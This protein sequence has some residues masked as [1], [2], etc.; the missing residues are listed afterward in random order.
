VSAAR[1]SPALSSRTAT[2]RS[3]CS[4]GARG[5]RPTASGVSLARVG[6]SRASSHGSAPPSGV[7]VTA[8]RVAGSSPS[9]R[10]ARAS[11]KPSWSGSARSLAPN[12]IQYGRSGVSRAPFAPRMTNR[13][14]DGGGAGSGGGTTQPAESARATTNAARFCSMGRL[15]TGPG[16]ARGGRGTCA[17]GVPGRSVPGC[18][19]LFQAEVSCNCWRL[20]CLCSSWAVSRRRESRAGPGLRTPGRGRRTPHQSVGHTVLSSHLRDTRRGRWTGRTPRSA[21][22]FGTN[23]VEIFPTA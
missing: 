14:P 17:V 4:P 11:R 18:V 22:W 16:E 7:R 21:S 19:T 5:S 15:L 8:V 20:P 23:S 3:S 6:A 1:R 9:F 12:G 10:I 2:S 13:G